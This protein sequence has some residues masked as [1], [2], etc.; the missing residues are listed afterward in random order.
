MEIE[1]VNDSY[2]N[3]LKNGFKVGHIEI[4]KG[5]YTIEVLY[6]RV[7]IPKKQRKLINPSQ[8]VETLQEK[9]Y[10]RIKYQEFK[11]IEKRSNLRNSIYN[12]GREFTIVK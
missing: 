2:V 7:D 11:E 8:V 5:V 6:S 1:K 10:N 3:L 12:T 4:H 9:I